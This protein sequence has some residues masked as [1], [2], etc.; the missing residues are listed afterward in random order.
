MCDTVESEVKAID[1]SVV[2]IKPPKFKVL[3]GGKT[4]IVMI[5]DSAA[6]CSIIDEYTFKPMVVYL[7]EKTHFHVY[8]PYSISSTTAFS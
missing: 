2:D 1:A 3:I 6:T 8:F 5:A 7:Q 4:E